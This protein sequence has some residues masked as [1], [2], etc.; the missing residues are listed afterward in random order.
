MVVYAHGNHGDDT[1]E[2]DEEED[3]GDTITVLSLI[4]ECMIENS[5][6]LTVPSR[7]QEVVCQFRHDI[8]D[9]FR[10]T[11]DDCHDTSLLF[12]YDTIHEWGVFVDLLWR[13]RHRLVRE[14]TEYTAFV[15]E[16]IT[17]IF[18]GYCMHSVV[19]LY[20][21]VSLCMSLSDDQMEEEENLI[22]T[23]MYKCFHKQ[24]LRCPPWRKPSYTMLQF[25]ALMLDAEEQHAMLDRYDIEE[26]WFDKIPLPNSCEEEEEG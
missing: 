4:N 2:E 1:N 5:N 18:V 10:V 12:V 24:H 7:R 6:V 11:E 19:T 22:F 14:T 23:H 26:G 8:P 25:R 15:K 17:P 9:T 13:M 16:F 21:Y 20:P 3:D